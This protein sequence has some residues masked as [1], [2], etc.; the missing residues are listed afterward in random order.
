MLERYK[1]CEKVCGQV[2]FKPD[3][4]SIRKELYSHMED[5]CERLLASGLEQ[6]AAEAAMLERMGDPEEV[7]RALDRV[8]KPWLGWLWKISRW[9]VI[10]CAVGLVLL[11]LTAPKRLSVDLEDLSGVSFMNG[12]GLR[13]YT[14]YSDGYLFVLDQ[15]AFWENSSSFDGAGTVKLRLTV[16]DILGN[17]DISA[18]KNFV[19]ADSEGKEYVWSGYRNESEG[20]DFFYMESY[21]RVL[22]HTYAITLEG[23]STE[24]EWVELRYTDCGR[25]LCLRV[26]LP[27]GDVS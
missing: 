26:D 7:G 25:S 8:H 15:I 10:L 4:G 27:G 19:I 16:W 18:V 17:G 9:L 23:V 12:V 2:R 6:E 24:T 22:R 11:L 20:T 13:G 1:W 5:C 21:T 3:H 14:H